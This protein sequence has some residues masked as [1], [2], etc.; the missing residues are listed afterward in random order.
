MLR[1]S[2]C[3]QKSASFSRDVY[4]VLSNLL[5]MV[6]SAFLALVWEHSFVVELTGGREL[7]RVQQTD[8]CLRFSKDQFKKKKKK[9]KNW[10]LAVRLLAVTDIITTHSDQNHAASFS[11]HCVHLRRMRKCVLNSRNIKMPMNIITTPP[12]IC[13]SARRRLIWNKGVTQF[14][15][16]YCSKISYTSLWKIKQ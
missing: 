14:H 5:P 16:S 4:W 11:V 13:G 7:W 8:Y 12:L 1:F 9:N 10:K 3:K 6:G 15:V 2:L